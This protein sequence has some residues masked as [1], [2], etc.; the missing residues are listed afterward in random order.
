MSKEKRVVGDQQSI[1]IGGQAVDIDRLLC[2]V[3]LK[4]E[5]RALPVGTA[6]GE[7]ETEAER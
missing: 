1:V 3:W 5:H 4:G 2:R 7:D 6:S